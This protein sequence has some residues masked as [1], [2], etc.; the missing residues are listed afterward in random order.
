ML[1]HDVQ[2]DIRIYLPAAVYCVAILLLLQL[3]L[4][5]VSAAVRHRMPDGKNLFP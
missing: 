4:L 2:A 1:L 3:L 5:V